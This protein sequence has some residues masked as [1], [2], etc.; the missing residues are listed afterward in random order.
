MNR[1][2]ILGSGAVGKTLASGFKKHGYEVRIG[3]RTPAKLAEFAANTGIEAATFADVAA[4]AEG[5]VLAVHG[6]SAEEALRLAGEAN[7]RGKLVIDTTNPIGAAPPTDGVLTYFT[8]PNESLL[9]RLQAAFPQ[10]RLVKA[11]NSVGNARMVNPSFKGGRPTMFYC[12][13]D[14]AAKADVARILDQFGWDVADM[15]KAAGARAIEPLCQ[16]W[17]IT[18]FRENVW[19]HAFKLVRE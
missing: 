7:V 11:F 12:G 6:A 16:L 15:G 14:D 10:A 1:I 17:C 4:W 5:L 18:G 2:G 13:N 8:G 19:T 9:E 3:S